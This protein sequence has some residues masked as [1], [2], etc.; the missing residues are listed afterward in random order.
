MSVGTVAKGLILIRRR[1]L[2]GERSSLN[3]TM[4]TT[5][6]ELARVRMPVKPLPVSWEKLPSKSK[7]DYCTTTELPLRLNGVS[8][9]GL[10]KA[11][12]RR[13][14]GSAA[15]SRILDRFTLKSW[16]SELPDF[17]GDDKV[18]LT[19]QIPYKSDPDFLLDAPE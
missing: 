5:S 15:R 16:Q 2:A 4:P 3:S 17:G 6:R 18:R 1:A 7:F 13:S 8:S 14:L 10:P 9:C 12:G 11:Q 19:Q